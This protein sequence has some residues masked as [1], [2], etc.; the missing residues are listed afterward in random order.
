MNDI[1]DREN[2]KIESASR[3]KKQHHSLLSN[4]Q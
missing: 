4:E 3:A 2:K 1:S